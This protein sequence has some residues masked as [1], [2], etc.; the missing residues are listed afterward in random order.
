[1][2]LPSPIDTEASDD[3][4][5]E[6]ISGGDRE[7]PEDDLAF[8]R[9]G[10]RTGASV[11]AIASTTPGRVPLR[12][13]YVRA[14]TPPTYG[15]NNIALAEAINLIGS[16]A[17]FGELFHNI[18]N[19]ATAILT[20]PAL[21]SYFTDLYEDNPAYF[22]EVARLRQ[23]GQH[24]RQAQSNAFMKYGAIENVMAAIAE[25]VNPGDAKAYQVA[26]N[27][28]AQMALIS[29]YGKSLD[30]ETN[31]FLVG[32]L[33]SIPDTNIIPRQGMRIGPAQF[34]L[35]SLGDVASLFQEDR[36][37][38]EEVAAEAIAWLSENPL[39]TDEEHRRFITW[40][41]MTAVEKT[42]EMSPSTGIGK[43]VDTLG[44]VLDAP[45]HLATEAAKTVLLRT[46]APAEGLNRNALSFGQIVALTVGLNPGDEPGSSFLNHP[47]WKLA[48]G[49][50]EYGANLA[51]PVVGAVSLGR[52]IA[53]GEPIKT[54]FLGNLATSFRASTSYEAMSGSADLLTWFALDPVNYFAAAGLGVK[55]AAAVIRPQNLSKGRA[56]LRAITPFYG[57]RSLGVRGGI[58]SR[59]AW[60]AVSQTADEMVDTVRHT[61]KGRR[62]FEIVR[63]TENVNEL[64]RMVP[65]VPAPFLAELMSVARVT[66]GKAEDFFWETLRG[67]LH[68]WN[69]AGD[70]GTF[71]GLTGLLTAYED[72]IKNAA[73][74]HLAD[75]TLSIR[76]VA[77]RFFGSSPTV[78]E[79]AGGAWKASVTVGDDFPK[80]VIDRRN[81]TE[82][83]LDAGSKATQ[84]MVENLARYE[85]DLAA[86]VALV[87]EGTL[88]S[89]SQVEVDA[90]RSWLNNWTEFDAVKF[91][92]EYIFATRAEPK[93]MGGLDNASLSQVEDVLKA[94][95]DNAVAA[96]G[97]R[98]QLG[99]RTHEIMLIHRMPNV[100]SGV[101]WRTRIATGLGLN[102]HTRAGEFFRKFRHGISS[103][104][105]G[106][107]S[108]RDAVKGGKNLESFM[109]FL[110]VNNP[111]IDEIMDE[112]WRAETIEG[113]YTT[114]VV[115]MR[116]I[117]DALDDPH[118]RWGL[119]DFWVRH[120]Q[121]AYY[122]N[123]HGI[124][125]GLALDGEQRVVIP[126]TKRLMT[127]SVPLPNALEMQRAMRRYRFGAKHPRLI[128]GLG[129]TNQN[130]MTLAEQV[131]NQIRRTQGPKVAEALTDDTALAIAYADV[132]GTDRISGL[133][134]VGRMART[135][136]KGYGMF[137][138]IFTVSQLALRPFAWA[139]RVNLEE[140]TRGWMMGLPTLFQN[141][142]LYL[143]T[144]WDSRYFVRRPKMY[145]RQ[146]EALNGFLKDVF[147]RGRS[148][149]EIVAD[150]NMF[151]PGFADKVTAKGITDPA[152][153]RSFASSQ[154]HRAMTGGVDELNVGSRL[155][156]ARRT[157]W[158]S[159][160]IERMNKRLLDV[161]GIP[162]DAD[163]LEDVPEMLNK[164]NVLTF[165][166]ELASS[167]HT[168]NWQ[169]NL[170]PR[171]IPAYA[172]I[173]LKKTHQIV[174]D[175]AG[176][177][178]LGRMVE[179]ANGVVSEFTAA[180]FIRTSYWQDVRSNI[181]KIARYRGL[182][183]PTEEA[184]AIFYLDTIM[185]DEYI[186]S[187]FQG[188]WGDNMVERQRIIE[189]LYAGETLSAAVGEK[190]FIVPLR[191]HQYAGGKTP[192]SAL[193]DEL[194]TAQNFNFPELN[195]VFSAMYADEAEPK[196]FWRR[197]TDNTLQVFGEN[198]S[199]TFHRRPSY[200]SE[201]R[202]WKTVLDGLGW[203]AADSAHYA[204]Q[205]AYEFVNYTF[206][207]NQHVGSTVHRMNRAVPFFSAWAEV[208]GTWTWKIPS[209]NFA[210]IGYANMV[211][212]IDR[213]MQGL[214]KLGLVEKAE[215]GQWYLNLDDDPISTMPLGNALSASGKSMLEAPM[216]LVEQAINIG[217]WAISESGIDEDFAGRANLS[218]WYR[219]GYALAIGSPIHLN[220]HGIMGVNQ[221]Q[222]GLSPPLNYASQIILKKAPFI[223]D[224]QLIEG[225]NLAHIY[226]RLPADVSSAQF[227]SM[228]ERTLVAAWGQDAYNL[229]VSGALGPDP[230][231]MAYR[232]EGLFL[233]VP[234]SG[235]LEGFIDD[236][237]YP[238]GKVETP[239]GIIR[240][241]VP[242]SI[243][244]MLRGGLGL[245]VDDMQDLEG[246]LSIVTGPV[247]QYQIDAE[248]NRQILSL[249]AEE[250]LITQAAVLS[251]RINAIVEI[252]GAT[253]IEGYLAKAL[254]GSPE[255]IEMSKLQMDLNLL[256]DEIMKRATDAALST[257][258]VRGFMG[259]FGPASPR[260]IED[261]A[262][263][264]AA[265]YASKD[266]AE[267]ALV[268]GS[269]NFSELVGQTKV[270]S[271]EEIQRVMGLMQQW[272]EDP[273]GNQTKAWFL[274]NYP[275]LMAFTQGI[276]FYGPGGVP[277]A[278]RDLDLFFADLAA[279]LRMPFPPDVLMQKV[280]RAAIAGGREGAIIQ[281]TGSND[282]YV[283]AEWILS[284]PTEASEWRN[285]WRMKLKALD[286][287]DDELNG[288]AY[289]EWQQRNETD[290][291]T[292]YAELE[293][294]VYIMEDI[295]DDILAL[296]EIS[297]LSEEDQ[298]QYR[299]LTGRLIGEYRNQ[300]EELRAQ[301]VG[302]S[303]YLPVREQIVSEYYLSIVEPYYAARQ[304][305]F[306]TLPDLETNTARASAWENLRE[307]ENQHFL[308]LHSVTYEGQTITVPSV[309]EHNWA[310]MEE[311]EQDDRVVQWIAKP[312]GWLSLFAISKMVEQSPALTSYLPGT[313]SAQQVY[314]EAQTL[315][316]QAI[317][318]ARRDPDTISK[319]ERDQFIA[320]IDEWLHSQ[321]RVQ[322]RH[323]ELVWLDAWPIERLVISGQLPE[324]L[325][326]IAS[327]YKGIKENLAAREEPVGPGSGAG[328]YQFNAL[329]I[330]LEETYY[331]ANPQAQIDIDLLG[332]TMF[333]T[334]N[335][336]ET[337]KRL[338]GG[339]SG[340]L[341]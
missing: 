223:G 218:D 171:D 288:S 333:G 163:L 309:L 94:E 47:L 269:V 68:G 136:G 89:L 192:A 253:S 310:M 36:N 297:S 338:Y 101:I 208:L 284:N 176:K 296:A 138:S 319:Y 243:S 57:S 10:V 322:G 321:L 200:M 153:L 215:G 260:M 4:E 227:L 83:S 66:G 150:V 273:T 279:G 229:I 196:N 262:R 143:T 152:S 119:R 275:S 246:L 195:G 48:T 151:L 341:D 99:A 239:V 313:A 238:F 117:G 50:L 270:T 125:I 209:A 177:F 9:S 221:F 182:D 155:N 289:Q 93:I 137:H 280:A 111:L 225:A 91:G 105:P 135:A 183:N 14:N 84:D 38:R 31:D 64:S 149:Q 268:R 148:T 69:E 147:A 230:D 191:D 217:R 266:A 49:P 312:T 24:I 52:M 82:L 6:G 87:Q 235:W 259:F 23:E 120:G 315:R 263:A 86:K 113:R 7:F 174:N 30:A 193:F 331:A 41:W 213:F 106:E 178:T 291:A 133:G 290:N 272:Y 33:A 302:G 299:Q 80:V 146:V 29:D 159:Q 199:Q 76:S 175:Y 301:L 40:F 144:M 194:Y 318:A 55:Q 110:G 118:L 304:E 161:Y 160:R 18:K 197:M 274:G 212:K 300:F 276:T 334:P 203:S 67:A 127:E 65:G 75:G 73:R 170:R 61:A 167:V 142:S 245:F 323:D 234:D 77:R 189:E 248:V 241:I 257:L 128:R 292:V 314:V 104:I 339:F 271:Y 207:N 255:S 286:M 100:S 204:N 237:F 264:T 126:F 184:L 92:D 15:N 121:H 329:A 188:L 220:S 88:S 42:N 307:L 327:W 219:D 278:Q 102:S 293:E 251:G 134:L 44:Y 282:P 17:S 34:G 226:A 103:P 56:F 95:L 240:E 20:A 224:T 254:P 190:S 46:T 130:R 173:W 236:Q 60:A 214:V 116:K 109:R 58:T 45:K 12:P 283:Q 242:A 335:R 337:Y 250:G 11:T 277:A 21:I 186:V 5:L 165:A 222:I 181:A 306:D 132:I 90:V 252:S 25:Q 172:R 51:I 3:P 70:P 131:K 114:F 154:L 53:G 28:P 232:T 96:Y 141:P 1:V 326:E 317:E 185:R 201:R 265:W 79:P 112:W 122:T 261:E 22:D 26:D 164:W 216:T 156:M 107:V 287:W 43:A 267:D 19:S 54:P 316:N 202:R 205:R 330:Y 123:S 59:M 169:S 37:P 325:M 211:H 324:S 124:E 162:E 81:W 139:T 8:M 74:L 228:N 140:H 27:S 258:L 97:I 256:N 244:F 295:A 129:T 85:P 2:T 62:L 157:I 39:D 168:L 311:N 320:K 71:R 233:Q 231:L 16:S 247:E 187:H 336:Y 180:N 145:Q 294:Q 98:Q 78:Y 32:I 328:R 332:E 63:T 115:G 108:F 303:S 298:E 166:D 179:A 210:P 281:L 158:R 198:V 35:P 206:F 340:E 305:I 308:S 249:E 72:D 13:R 285:T